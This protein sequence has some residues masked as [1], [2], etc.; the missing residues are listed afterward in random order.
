MWRLGLE[1]D[2]RSQQ[3]FYKILEPNW[4]FFQIKKKLEPGQEVFL[5]S[6]NQTTLKLGTWAVH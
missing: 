5:K 3:I 4:R 6:K 2:W 1:P